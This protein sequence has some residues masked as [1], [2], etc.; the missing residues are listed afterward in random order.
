[1]SIRLLREGAARL[2]QCDFFA[3]GEALC[4]ADV[5]AFNDGGQENMSRIARLGGTAAGV[6]AIAIGWAIVGQAAPDARTFA[7]SD[8]KDLVLLN[9]KA[10]AVEYKGRKGRRV[11]QAAQKTGSG[12]R[13]GRV[14]EEAPI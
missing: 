5:P 1:M 9:V 4:A 10:E 11:A 6:F 3:S 8:T 7:L 12:C 14:V 2:V 13:R